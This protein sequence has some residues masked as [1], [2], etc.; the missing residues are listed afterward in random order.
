MSDKFFLG[1]PEDFN[2]KLQVYPPK[3]KELVENS[4]IGLYYHLLTLSQ[5]DI[6]DE[7]SKNEE[8]KTFPTP[9]EFLM[10]NCYREKEYQHL[11]RE[12]FKYFC[13]TDITFL[14][15]QKKILIGS[16]EDIVEQ[17]KQLDKNDK[18]EEHLT[19][20]EE[21]EFFDFQ[22]LVRQAYSQK[23]IE[24][25]NPDE[26]PRVRRIKAKG[27]MREKLKAKK[28]G[29]PT[30]ETLM[31]AICCM[32]IGLTPLNIGEI[33]YVAANVLVGLYQQRES[34]QI[35]V[36]S[37][38]AGADSKKVKPKYWIRNLDKK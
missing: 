1:F 22:N 36:D 8:V 15:E 14:Y 16:P 17:V 32:G 27:R 3:L 13:H 7:L 28:G 26:D 31:G 37:I 11:A 18:I 10:A 30:L 29:G 6:E 4:E 25:P 38:L 19:I 2:G 20:L 24:R 23:P 34:Y 21:K 9:Y 12:A 35:D 33:T 5:E